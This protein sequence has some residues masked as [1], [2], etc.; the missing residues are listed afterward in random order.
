MKYE[1]RDITQE[2]KKKFNDN[3]E[4]EN[5][6]INSLLKKTN[7]IMKKILDENHIY[8][9]SPRKKDLQESIK[10]PEKVKFKCD[11]KSHIQMRETTQMNATIK[12]Y[13]NNNYEINQP[14][15]NKE[16][17]AKKQEIWEYQDGKSSFSDNRCGKNKGDHIY[18]I[19]ENYEIGDI[20][21]SDSPWNKIP[22]THSENVSWKKLKSLKKNLVYDTFTEEEIEQFTR[23]QLDSY[24]KLKQWK[25]Y[26]KSRGA[27]LY[28]TNGRE[29]NKLCESI[30]VP[31][32]SKLDEDCIALPRI[33]QINETNQKIHY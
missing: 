25:D 30:V 6:D 32:Q 13:I 14:D 3:I 8:Y 10:N 27:K 23:E 26:C 16:D 11:K 31:N 28:W 15:F 24:N 4:T 12:D 17:E 2:E 5:T 33:P 21:G 29:I 7:P 20:I 1:T 19:R 22:C 18:G 9:Q